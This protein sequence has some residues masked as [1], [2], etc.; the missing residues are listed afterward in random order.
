MTLI[1]DL[2]DTLY[3][4]CAPFVK[5]LETALGREIPGNKREWYH[6]YSI[7]SQEM[8]EAQA[9]GE[10]SLADSRILRIRKAMK[11]FK[12]PFSEEQEQVY[13][14]TYAQEQGNVWMSDTIKELMELGIQTGT[15]MAVLTNGPVDHQLKKAA[16]LQLDRWISRDR[17]FISEE[18]GYTKP[19]VE[20]F[21]YVKCVMDLEPQK[22][23]MIGDS[24]S[25]DIEGAKEAGWKTIWLNKNLETVPEGKQAPDYIAETEE[26]L[27]EIVKSLLT[28]EKEHES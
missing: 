18:I 5:A 13:Q 4:R 15:V 17:L 11:H 6:I 2:D 7:C 1:F 23:W 24:F 3:D 28:K 12:V 9:R 19:D 26:E 10:V 20:T 27:L 14:N 16:T 8:F 22:T 21:H 25:S